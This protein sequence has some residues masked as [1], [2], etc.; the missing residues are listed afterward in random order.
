MFSS[1]S[2]VSYV[3]DDVQRFNFLDAVLLSVGVYRRLKLI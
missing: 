2:S 1:V 3:D